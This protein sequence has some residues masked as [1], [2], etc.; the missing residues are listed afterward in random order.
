MLQKI[1]E[2]S[3]NSSTRSVN[4]HTSCDYKSVAVSWN[5]DCAAELE[6]PLESRRKICP[7]Q[8]S[9]IKRFHTEHQ[10]FLNSRAT[11]RQAV[12]VDRGN[13][14]EETVHVCREAHHL[15]QH[16]QESSTSVSPPG[17]LAVPVL[18]QRE[19]GHSIEQDPVA[20]P[21]SELAG[22]FHPD[23]ASMMYDQC[24]NFVK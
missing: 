8:V 5:H 7:K 21:P 20:L 2:V 24:R 16:L 22:W 1:A 18:A 6:K 12:L 4:Q 23:M 10:Q 13:G 11:S 3:R 17:Q 14:S 9:H 15:R 19:G